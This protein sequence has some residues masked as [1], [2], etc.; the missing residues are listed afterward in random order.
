MIPAGD[1]KTLEYAIAYGADS[2]YIGGRSFN[3]RSLGKNFSLKGLKKAVSISR[4][5]NIKIYLTLNSIVSEKETSQLLEY[6]SEI[7]D[8][9]FDAIIVSD[10]G[11]IKILKRIAPEARLHLS[12]QAN[13]SN[14]NAVNF[15]ASQGISRVNL[16]REL[17]F[18]EIN[19][20]RKNTDIEI[21]V[22]VHGALCIS[23]SGRC[24]LSKY[25]TGR[26]AN[27]GECAHSCRWKYYLMEEERP[28]VFY[29]VIQDLKGSYIYNSRDLCL[30]R[31]IDLLADTGID[32]LKIEGRMKTENYISQVTWTYRRALDHCADGK[33]DDDKKDYLYDQLNKISHRDYTEGFMF[34]DDGKELIDNE[35][36]GYINKYRFVGVFLEQDKRLDGPCLYVKNQFS[37]EETIDILQPGEKPKEA[38]IGKIIDI[39]NGNEIDTANPN[40]KVV[41]KGLGR[42]NKYSIFRIKAKK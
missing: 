27:K 13:I 16:A 11:I 20:I 26:D 38:R 30:I 36:V 8:I 2:V 3:L 42:F 22:F 41:L 23:Y 33:Y 28:N 29:P 19:S 35:N 10:A 7:K 5:K 34:L 6:I 4:E 24:M 14:S 21:E 37:K 25:M 39:K 17:T 12:T 40:D 31:R 1:I 15:W 18:R 32:S 9:G